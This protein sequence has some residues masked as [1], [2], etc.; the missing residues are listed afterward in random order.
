MSFKNIV[1]AVLLT[2]TAFKP[3]VADNGITFNFFKCEFLSRAEVA[4]TAAS[5]GDLNEDMINDLT[6]Q[7]RADLIVG[8][9][10]R[11][12]TL[13]SELLTDRQL[14][15]QNIGSNAVGVVT[16]VGVAAYL[17]NLFRTGVNMG[18][19]MHHSNEAWA[20]E[21][22]LFAEWSEAKLFPVKATEFNVQQHLALSRFFRWET[23]KSALILAGAMATYTA[24][25]FT[26]AVLQGVRANHEAA[27]AEL[28]NLHGALECIN[29]VPQQDS[30]QEVVVAID[31]SFSV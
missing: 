6:P 4:L 24:G 29:A 19:W 18:S 2:L 21:E 20:K 15:W 7:D 9:N 8:I 22:M 14:T 26:W 16:V 5:N 23:G 27:L 13:Q 10:N 28:E 17:Y 12:A 11:I 3:A 30:T 25:A 1:A 31:T